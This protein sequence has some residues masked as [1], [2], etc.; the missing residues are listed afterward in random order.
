MIVVNKYRVWCS[1]E[2]AYVYGWGVTEPTTCPTDTAHTI[3]ST[4]TTIDATVEENTVEIK[5]ENT[6]TGGQYKSCG[7][8]FSAAA[9]EETLHDFSFPFPISLMSATFPSHGKTAGDSIGFIVGPDTVVGAI[10]SDVTAGDT[11]IN[12][13]STVIDNMKAGRYAR[14]DD[15]TNNEEHLVITVGSTT[16]TLHT[17]TAN[18]Y[19]AATPTYV[20]LN[21]KMAENL[22]L[23][24]E[25]RYMLGDTKIGGS[26]VP[27]NTVI[28]MSYNNTGVSSVTVRPIFEFLY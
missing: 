2:G 28:R 7:L 8:S 1:T 24:P 6:P 22:Y 18:S 21:V 13:Q 12:V 25:V 3:D 19:A 20:K 23:E 14:L 27:A 17:A 4:K 10:T 16:I 5:E 15:G 26:Y 11:V 9:S